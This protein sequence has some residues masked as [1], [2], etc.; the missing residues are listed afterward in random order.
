MARPLRIEYPG[1]IYH[2]MSRGNG[3]QKTFRND[4]DFQ[5]L[6]EG[7]ESA[8]LKFDW[9]VMNYV[10]MP[11]HIHLF[12]KTPQPNLSAGMQYLLSGYANW[13][14]KRHQRPGHLFQGRYKSFVVEDDSYFWT[15]SRYIHLNPCRGGR[16]DGSG[17][18]DARGGA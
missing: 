15:L 17:C 16:S 7:L 14:S 3:R 18:P 8:V 6:L 10:W 12:L 5:R 4:G 11:N 9:L 2:V 1:A 13:F